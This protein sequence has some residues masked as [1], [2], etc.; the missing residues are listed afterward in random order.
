MTLTEQLHDLYKETVMNVRPDVFSA[1]EKAS[2]EENNPRAQNIFKMIVENMKLAQSKNL[3][4]CQDTGTPMFFVYRCS[5]MPEL[6][7]RNA[8][9]EA[10]NLATKEKILRPNSYDIITE[11]NIGN[12]PEI[13]SEEWPLNYTEI[14]LLLK[15]GGSENVGRVL[16]PKYRNLDGVREEVLKVIFEIQGQACPP[17]IVGICIGGSKAY[18]M[19]RANEMLFRYIDDRNENSILA[20][21]EEEL[22]NDINKLGIGP[23]GVG[24]DTT[25]LG[26]KICSEPRHA[27]TYNV[28]LSYNC[29]AVRTGKTRYEN[30]ITH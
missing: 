1:L 21:L 19:R 7:I 18:S 17:G 27:A 11:E 29:Y 6:E 4:V 24:G 30:N 12:C 10:T 16:T 15:G 5:T 13:Y 9:I 26:V 25:V 28:A 3:F 22:K 23:M 14:K 20:K 2:S 8:I